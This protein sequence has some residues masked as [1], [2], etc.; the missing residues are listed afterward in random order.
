MR[1]LLIHAER[2]SFSSEQEALEKPPDPPASGSFENC[3]VVFVTVE[4][5]DGADEAR[6]AAADAVAQAKTVRASAIVVYPYAHLSSRVARPEEAYGVLLELEKAI[7]SMWEGLVARA[8]FGWYKSFQL[9]CKGHPL[10][11]LS[12]SFAGVQEVRYR[13]LPLEE[14]V[15]LELVDERALRRPPWDKDVLE[16]YSRLR[17]DSLEGRRARVE[18]EERAFRALGLRKLAR[19]SEPR[20]THGLRGVAALASLCSKLEPGILASWGDVGDS[21]AS[22]EVDPRGFLSEIDSELASMLEE[23]KLGE[24]GLSVS[25]LQGSVY[26]YRARSGGL[27]PLVVELPRLKCLGPLSSIVL[28]LIDLGLRRAERG[29]TPSLPFWL[30]PIQVALLPVSE[31][32]SSFVERVAEKLSEIGVRFTV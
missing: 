8:P 4:E 13:G 14:A 11:E 24:E 29:R 32:H 7:S 15:A 21:V 28:S 17:F 3:L 20:W 30:A 16:A 12:R 19:I 22:T 26:A 27:A 2:F 10:A 6:L 18:L 5:G 31:K 25:S 9:S 23:V 1:V